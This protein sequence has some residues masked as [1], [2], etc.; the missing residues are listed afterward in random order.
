VPGNRIL[1]GLWNANGDKDVLRERFGHA[2]PDFVAATLREA[3]AQIK[4][5]EA[6]TTAVRWSPTAVEAATD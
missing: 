3:L 4:E 6:Q 1:I 2:R 5:C